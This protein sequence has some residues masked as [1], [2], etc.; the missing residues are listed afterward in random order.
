VALLKT[1]LLL[2]PAELAVYLMWPFLPTSRLYRWLAILLLASP[3]LNTQILSR[4]VSIEVEEDYLYAFLGLAF[5]LV[6]L[7]RRANSWLARHPGVEGT[8]AG[9][10]IGLTY[11]AKSSMSITAFVLLA[12]YVWKTSERKAILAAVL[13]SLSAPVGWALQQHHASGRY[14]IGTSIDGMN[15]HK[16]NNAVFLSVYPLP[17]MQ[18]LDYLD[19]RLNTGLYFRNEWEFNDYHQKAAV[20]FL[21]SHP[22]QMFKADGQKLFNI[23]L[24]L[25]NNGGG[26]K[27]GIALRLELLSIFLFRLVFWAALLLSAAAL[28]FRW[29]NARSQSW[30]YLALVFAVAVPYTLGFPFT[31]HISILMLPSVFL[32]CYQLQAWL[33]RKNNFA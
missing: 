5:A 23:F 3:F 4:I 10:A 25:Q 16:G 11:L 21:K 32:C 2:V 22:R 1:L 30:L 7:P 15:L 13:I 18:T 9:F 31:R 29:T 19:Y 8:L 24:S 33:Q 28:L 12:A 27:V 20:A 17:P 26:P 6:L 14:T